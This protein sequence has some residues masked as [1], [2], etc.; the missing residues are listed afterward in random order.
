[1]SQ[2]VHT[3]LQILLILDVNAIIRA[4]ELTGAQG[5][6]RELLIP[7]R[8]L[9]RRVVSLSE[10]GA[11]APGA[12][13]AR[14]PYDWGGIALGVERMATKVREW[15]EEFGKPP[16]DV[17]VAGKAPLPVFVH[18]G[19]ALSKFMHRQ[20]V[21]NQ[22]S[23]GPWERFPLSEPTGTVGGRFFDIVQGLDRVAGTTG[24]VAIVVST[25]GSPMSEEA[26]RRFLKTSNAELAGTVEIR[27]SDVGK[28]TV[29]NATAVAD[30][31]AGLLSRVRGHY[32]NADGFAVCIAGPAQLAFMVGRAINPN[33]Y[34]DVWIANYGAGDYERAIM[35]PFRDPTRS[36]GQSDV[37]KNAHRE[38]LDAIVAGLEA[39]RKSLSQDDLPDDLLPRRRARFLE[40][41]KTVQIS[42][43]IDEDEFRLR[44]LRQELVLGRGLLEA[45]RKEAPE[46]QAGIGQLLFLHEL[47]HDEHQDLRS[48]NYHEIGRAGVALEALDY[49]ADAFALSVLVSSKVRDGG[50]AA[51]RQLGEIAARHVEWALRG[52]AA[53]DRLQHGDRIERL[54]ERRLRRYL[55]WALQRE[56]AGVMIHPEHVAA[57]FHDRL[58]VELAPLAGALDHRF[59]KLV[60]G[61]LADTELVL[62]LRGRLL[63]K[64][65]APGFNPGELVERVRGF[66]L[67]GLS[68]VMEVLLD[69]HRELLLPWYE[70]P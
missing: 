3:P 65:R 30:E 62:C 14:P 54:P 24:R 57:V 58:I 15:I 63:R 13:G 64:G 44:V 67:D 29:A 52:M 45:L 48:T 47:Y 41:V 36:I 27:T 1:M 7:D 46:V 37:D 70:A 55:I 34:G 61:L 49:H 23:G 16:A 50:A 18:L 19:Y 66:D 56:R 10:C 6:D 2:P 59:D 5:A 25:L 42:K 68:R 32:P 38:V 12:D 22:Q 51:L 33:I 60:T 11:P 20:A 35:L 40:L 21:L 53:F 31:L 4:Q 39:L 9:H 69:N 28:I 43:K 17:Y 26:I 8:R